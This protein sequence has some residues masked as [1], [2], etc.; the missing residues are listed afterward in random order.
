MILD[1][2][3]ECADI[4]EE[5][6]KKIREGKIAPVSFSMVSGPYE[7]SFEMAFFNTDTP[8][9]FNSFVTRNLR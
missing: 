3:A 6:A 1:S 2:P 7:D 4:L 9:D 8:R 5:F